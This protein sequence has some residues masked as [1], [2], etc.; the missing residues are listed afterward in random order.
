MAKDWPGEN[1]DPPKQN[2]PPTTEKVDTQVGAADMMEDLNTP[3][4]TRPSSPM[5]VTEDM[6]LSSPQ[7]DD[8]VGITGVSFKTL[9]TSSVLTKLV[10]KD[11]PVAS[12]KGKGKFELPNFED[13]SA[14]DLH[15]AYL[16]QL[17]VSQEMEVSLVNMLKK[18]YEVRNVPSF[19]TVYILCS[20]QVL[21][22]GQHEYV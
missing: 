17:S 3:S 4:P 1:V 22:I 15:E 8:D 11:E 7:D 12:E 19:H 9:E 13:L 2:E 10:S 21:D 14:A 6:V 5:K 16:T 18:K 20:R